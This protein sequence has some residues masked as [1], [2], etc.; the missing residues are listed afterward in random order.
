MTGSILVRGR[1]VVT[2]SAAPPLS[3]AAVLVRDASIAEIGPWATLRERHRDLEVLGSDRVAVL[4]GLINSHHHSS[5]VTALQHGIADDLLEPWILAHAR[6]RPGDIYLETLISAARL[7]ASGVTTVVDVKSGG[8]SADGFAD[9][10]RAG[11]KAHDEAGLRVAYAAGF[12]NQSFLVHGKGADEAFLESLPTEVRRLAEQLLPGPD[13]LDEDEYFGLME[14]I[15]RDYRDHPRIGLWF[16]PPGPQW[17]TDS[18]MQ[19]IAE[20]AEA[21]DAGIQ[22]HV[23]E[24]FYEKLHGRR[25]YG[26]PTLLHLQDLGVL[27][28]RFSIAHGVWL[29]E[30]EIEVLAESGAAVVHNPG[31]NLRLRA[32]IAP[33]TALL[34]AGASVALGMDGTGLAD[35]DDIFAEMRLALRLQRDP[36]LG[37][38]VPAPEEVLSLAT[39]GGAKLLRREASLGRLRPGF[40]ADLVLVDLERLTWPWVAP[41]A[42]PLMLI[43]LRARAGDV[44]TVMVAGETVYRDGRPT[45][46]DLDEAAGE[47]ARK[48]ALEAYPSDRAELV[49]RLT[50][51]LEAHYRSWEAPGGEPYIRHNSRR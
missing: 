32:G 46:F 12:G 28:P 33:L 5:G 47:L 35:D 29:S 2:E 27:S 31:S 13:R 25:C 7:M 39:E 40:A 51:F 45:R 15:W 21:L 50:P 9:M 19:E 48:L 3:D 11:L 26:K 24:S 34:E 37:H 43:L 20:R 10:V 18:F 6:M 42:D 16:G 8:G 1:W 30:A 23:N 38:R 4:P 41:E 36:V 22:T 14:D 17:V 49:R 44:T